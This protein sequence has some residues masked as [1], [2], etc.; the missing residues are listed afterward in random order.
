MTITTSW[1]HRPMA[2]AQLPAVLVLVQLLLY[3]LV[4]RTT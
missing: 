3:Q 1:S 2:Y 4:L